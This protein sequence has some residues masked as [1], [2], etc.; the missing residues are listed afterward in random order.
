MQ[1]QLYGQY[2]INSKM[3]VIESSLTGLWNV[4]ILYKDD[5]IEGWLTNE[6]D[7]IMNHVVGV[8]NEPEYQDNAVAIILNEAQEMIE[9]NEKE[10]INRI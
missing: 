9:Y 6:N 1:Y 10:T 8:P 4:L 7:G 2:T 5:V 3:Y